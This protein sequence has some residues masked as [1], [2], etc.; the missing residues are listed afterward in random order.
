MSDIDEFV[1]SVFADP[2]WEWFDRRR[3]FAEHDGTKI[4]VVLAT[5]TPQFENFALNKNDTDRLL[6]AKRQGNVNHAYIVFA[7]RNGVGRMEYHC[8]R[9]AESFYE[10]VLRHAQIIDGKY[11]PFWVIRPYEL[12]QQEKYF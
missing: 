11:G 3:Y 7:K 9:E 5:W 4:G 10:A 6:E 2:R 1:A 8:H 12:A